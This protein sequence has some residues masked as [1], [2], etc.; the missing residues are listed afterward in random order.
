MCERTLPEKLELRSEQ[1]TRKLAEMCLGHLK[2]SDTILLIGPVGIG[3]SFF[4][5]A[6]I[7]AQMKKDGYLEDVPSPTF[8]L[9]QEYETSLG[10]FCHADLY[11]LGDPSEL[12]ELGMADYLAEAICLIEWPE[13][14]GSLVPKR[15]LRVEM[16][17]EGT[18]EDRQIKFLP[19]GEGWS[20]I[21]ELANDYR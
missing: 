14:L 21:T 15:H 18:G 6:L 9:L 10:V 8:T 16:S 5:R 7:Q 17:F 2:P 3:K 20:W 13:R 12:E 4:A 11:R 19:S 1:D